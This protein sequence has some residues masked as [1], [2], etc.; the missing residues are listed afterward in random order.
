[1]ETIIMAYSSGSGVQE[2]FPFCAFN[3]FDFSASKLAMPLQTIV[4]KCNGEYT[5]KGLGFRF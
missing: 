1:M 2:L 4:P 5:V 3:A